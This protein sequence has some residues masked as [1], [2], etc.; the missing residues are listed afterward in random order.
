MKGLYAVPLGVPFLSTLVDELI[1]QTA[2]NPLS[3][4]KYLIILPTRRGCL[5]LQDA[6]LKAT[7]KG[8]RM[9]PRIIA[10]GD[11]EEGAEVPG[12]L[13]PKLLPPP[14][15]SWQRLGLMTQLVLTFEKQK[16]GGIHNPA[17]AVQLANDLMRLVDEVET[18]GLQLSNLETL[19]IGDYA[20]HW[21]VTLDFLKILTQE[22]PEILKQEGF[23]E[24]A[25]R[26][27]MILEQFIEHWRPT[28][29]VI[30]A[31][32]TATR[33][34]TA[35]LAEKILSCA[36]GSVVLVG[37]DKN[38]FSQNQTSSLQNTLPPTHPQYTTS[39]LIQLLNKPLKW[40][41][42]STPLAARSS[43]I[44]KAMMTTFQE[45]WPLENETVTEVLSNLQ[46]IE[47]PSV[48]EEAR[49]IALIM[50]YELEKP[51]KT[52]A[53]VTPDVELSRRV[54]SALGR[55]GVRANLSSGIPFSQS[56][57]GRF[58]S[59]SSLLVNDFTSADLLALLKHPLYAK[60]RDRESHL[61]TT[62]QF[63]IEVLRKLQPSRVGHLSFPDHELCHP[64]MRLNDGHSHP[65]TE[66]LKA[67]IEVAEALVGNA[68]FGATDSLSLLWSQEDGEV[69]LKFWK[70]L[71][72]QAHHF[73]RLT[74][75]EYPAF[76]RN[77][78][79]QEM[80]HDQ[81]SVK[82]RILIL[83]TLEARL[84]DAD[85][86]ILG[87]L[88]EGVWPG[89]PEEDPWLS[90]AMREKFGLPPIERKIGLSAHDF[91][92]TMMAPKVYMTRSLKREGAPT[93][94]SRWWQ[95]LVTLLKTGGVNMVEGSSQNQPWSLISM[96]LDEPNE[97]IT[98]SPPS[99]CPPLSIRP[100]RLS[101]TDV[102][103]LIRDPYSIYAKK[104]LNLRPLDPLE[105]DLS[106]SERGQAIHKIFDAFIRSG[107]DPASHQ[108]IPFIENLGSEA[109]GDLLSDPRAKAFWWPRYKR[110]S[111][112]FLDQL[113]KDQPCVKETKTEIEGQIDIPTRI[114]PIILSAKADRIDTM[115]SGLA[116]I[117]DYKTGAIPSRKQVNQGYAPQLTLEGVIMQRDGFSSI[118]TMEVDALSYWHVTGGTPAG[119]VISLE[120]TKDL[121]AAAEGGV[122]ELF[123][124]FFGQES[125]FH[126]CPNPF[127]IPEYHDYAHLERIKEWY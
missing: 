80:V 89:I 40:L 115:N 78:M 34:T 85:V 82:S 51:E 2:S 10:L 30:L 94:P 119:E 107:I 124:A 118:P 103:A 96:K 74:G 55:W 87:G 53:L 61:K 15:P 44:S 81:E 27:R 109:F 35:R 105:A 4:A 22:W 114:G 72:E 41:N 36:Q 1:T 32:T 48:M 83:G 88:N 18:T 13:P 75:R 69:G 101:V 112:W 19:V 60:G 6:F 86:V 12:Y 77:L 100:R 91:C 20:R 110:L 52:I 29:P 104:I 64:M 23:I 5:M 102:E 58:L 37:V 42:Q 43:L 90:R 57:V 79:F 17:G 126:A 95:R 45:D 59:L 28:Y 71:L 93:L 67:H 121:I 14:M 70:A 106:A 68:S 99:P 117:I 46:A 108:A 33:P 113:K 11:I 25:A 76:I 47:A 73:P 97:H 56:V 54:K 120:N 116:R 92:T 9:L 8:C 125:P 38:I 127:I 50:R 123:D 111:L 49:Q 24:P 62:S 26:K 66:F 3:L 31:G 65:F 21:Q 39:Q 98:F 122:Q 84:L 7:P 63:E 16:E